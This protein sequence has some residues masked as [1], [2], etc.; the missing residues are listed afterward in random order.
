MP[1][2]QIGPSSR[3]RPSMGVGTSIGG[4]S[5]PVRYSCAYCFP[6]SRRHQLSFRDS[7]R[8]HQQNCR[9]PGRL[10]RCRGSLQHVS[11]R[12]CRSCRS[13]DRSDPPGARNIDVGP[14]V[15]RA[16]A[17]TGR[18]RTIEITRHDT[19]PKAQ[20]AGCFDQEHR[21][22]AARMQPHVLPSSVGR[23]ENPSAPCPSESRLKSA[24]T[25]LINI[26]L[27]GSCPLGLAAS[28]DSK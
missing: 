6:A 17:D 2:G 3:L 21:E 4:A 26:C 9:R 12:C 23:S 24:R 20:A 28:T 19:S 11:S 15:S 7:Y 25:A 1:R 10:G 18:G 13:S 14:R 27:R 16:G 22:I 8:K 5:Q